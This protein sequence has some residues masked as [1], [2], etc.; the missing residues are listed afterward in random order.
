MRRDDL[1][2]AEIIR[3]DLT[4]EPRT[5]RDQPEAHDIDLS[6]GGIR[7]LDK[8]RL[9]RILATAGSAARARHQ[10]CGVQPV[11]LLKIEI[12]TDCS[13]DAGKG[14]NDDQRVAG[15]QQEADQDDRDRDYHENH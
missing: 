14:G 2:A 4:A 8:N 9:V 7:Q 15:K 6:V 3:I 12:E 11:G 13:A 5:L 1:V 10:A